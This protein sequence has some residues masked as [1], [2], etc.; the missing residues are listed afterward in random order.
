MA[1][2]G[3]VRQPMLLHR[4]QLLAGSAALLGASIA[5]RAAIAASY[6]EKNIEWIC[7][8]RSG[9]GADVATRTFTGHLEKILKKD[10]VVKNVTGGGGSIGYAAAKVAKPDGYTLVTLQGDLPKYKPMGQAPIDIG[11][12]DSIAGFAF[13]SPVVVVRADSP[14]KTLQNFV[15]DAKKNPGKYSVGVTDIGGVFHQPL[16]LFQALAGFE[17]KAVTFEGSPQQTVALLGGHVDALVTWVK[18]N[19]PYEKDGKVRFLGYMASER[20]PAFKQIPTLKEQGFDQIW[21]H[22]YGMGSPR[23]TPAEVR[24]VLEDAAKKIWEVPEFG[25]SLD[26]LGLSVLRMDG[27]AYEAHLNRMQADMAKAVALI[28]N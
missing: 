9:G 4:R 16:V 3:L 25:A 6:P 14:W 11:D 20:D 1:K 26:K 22:P 17:T 13:Q 12:F 5:S 2:L 18:P 10:I 8:W 21:Q 24:K 15:D 19:I 23:G 28:K 27:A 7:M